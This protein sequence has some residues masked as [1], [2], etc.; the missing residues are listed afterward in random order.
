MWA[1]HSFIS[2]NEDLNAG[3]IGP[4]VVYPSGKMNTTMASHREFTLLYSNFDESNS[5]M[6]SI[7]A[8]RH[9]INN[10]TASLFPLLSLGQGYRNE[11]I[12]GPQYT[13][14]A[15]ANQLSSSAAPLFHTLNGR[16]YAN[17]D[18]FQVC[19]N[20]PTIWYVYSF[21]SAAHSFHMHGNGFVYMGRNFATIAMQDG[22]MCEHLLKYSG[23]DQT[24]FL[25][26][27][28]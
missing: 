11:S 12:W 20:D 23:E 28:R 7:N 15:S 25:P 6:S 8:K 18:P 16:I 1:Y 22:T 21:G 4:T 5:F 19:V 26:L 13:N 24:R 10:A 14:L 9:G 3:L 2:M 17:N 27:C